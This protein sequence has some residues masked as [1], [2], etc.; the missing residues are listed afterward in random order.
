[1]A[2]AKLEIAIASWWKQGTK[3]DLALNN[4]INNFMSR[5]DNPYPNLRW[6][7]YYED[8]GFENPPVTTLVSDLNYIKQK[9]SQSPYFLKIGGKPVIF[10]YAGP[11]MV[12][13]P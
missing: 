8:E 6:S 5:S 2:E 4:I 10:V 3:E 11:L 9:F 7:I 13:E 12:Q 1:M